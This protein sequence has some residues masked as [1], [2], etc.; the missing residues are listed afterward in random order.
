MK[1]RV[2]LVASPA[3]LSAVGPVV[4]LRARACVFVD[5]WVGAAWASDIMA[6]KRG[7]RKGNYYLPRSSKVI[8]RRKAANGRGT[9]VHL[10][11][12]YGY[13]AAAA[14]SPRLARSTSHAVPS[15]TRVLRGC[16]PACTTAPSTLQTGGVKRVVG[17]C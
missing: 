5:V 6:I 14:G 7:K 15:L 3:T 11:R 10:N 17:P 1:Q 2:Q 13:A 9:M 8:Q 4:G 16:S 12:G